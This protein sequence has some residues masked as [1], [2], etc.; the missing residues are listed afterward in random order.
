MWQIHVYREIKLHVARLCPVDYAI[1]F[2]DVSVYK[3][4]KKQTKTK[5]QKKKN[6]DYAFAFE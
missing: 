4:R 3:T 6:V 2:Q 1:V 5:K